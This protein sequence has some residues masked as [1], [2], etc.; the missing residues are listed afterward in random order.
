M[1]ACAAAL[2]LVQADAYLP[3]QEQFDSIISHLRSTDRMT[4]SELEQFLDLDGREMLRRMYQGYLD[5]RGPGAVAEPVLDANG[6]E[7]THQ[8]LHSRSLTTIFGEVILDRQGY[9][10]RG[11]ESLHPLDAE[12]NLPPESYSH[13]VQRQIACATAK[14][15]FD[16]VVITIRN[17][18]GVAVPKRQVEESARRA[19]RDFELFY[20]QQR[21]QN[22][23][24]VKKTGPILAI[25]VDG[26]G[27]PMLKSDLREATRKAAEERQ[28]RLK[29]R[30]SPGE[31]TKTK[32]MSTVAAVYTIEPFVRAPEQIVREL[33]PI[34]EALPPRPRPEDKRVWASIKHPPEA[35]IKQAFEEAQRR[36][37]KQ[38]KEWIALVDGNETQL[39]FLRLAAKDYGVELV[40]ILDLIHVLEYLWKAAWAFHPLGDRA[41]ES[42]VGERL[43][44]ILRGHS[45][46]V[47]AGMRRSATL[48]GLS[49]LERGPIDDCAGYLL[50]YREFLH[51]DRYLAKGYPIATGVIE[52][53]CRYLVKD[54][55]EKTGARWSLEGAEAVL[56]LRS[57]RASGDFDEYWEFHLQ[58]EYKRNHES[59]YENGKVPK[60]LPAPGSAVK[61]S[62]LKLVK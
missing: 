59:Q 24:A 3:A 48:R 30:C 16:E 8:R 61:G 49:D 40:I 23:R 14:E 13:T 37:P 58:Q 45:S 27:V 29:H 1:A 19:S 17:Q 11:F 41:A 9:G 38:T 52:G 34:Q 54:R 32:R 4:H 15:S 5:E 36:D 7:H 60:P 57:L 22:A 26:K 10:G 35:I 33:A 2:G 12:L 53:A 55:M 21:S 39:D 28:P 56:Q 20:E 18:T 62:R 43:A 31:K 6:Q 44:E 25:T 46:S 47:A 51:Y 50:K 42:W